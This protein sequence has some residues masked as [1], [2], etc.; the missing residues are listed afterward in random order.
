MAGVLSPSVCGALF[1]P[2]WETNTRSLHFFFT[3]MLYAPILQLYLNV[4][5]ALL[6]EHFY[7]MNTGILSFHAQFFLPLVS[8]GFC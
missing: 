8:T 5:L 6:P 3:Q 7:L 4:K 2:S 1:W